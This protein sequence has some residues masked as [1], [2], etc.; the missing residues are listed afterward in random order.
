MVSETA[1]SFAALEI[2]SDEAKEYLTD[3]EK[4]I[5]EITELQ[6]KVKDYIE[7]NLYD[8]NRKAYV[9]NTNDRRMDISLLKIR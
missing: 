9:R 1:A 7:N 3:T 5:Q 8:E 2:N 6:V 4:N